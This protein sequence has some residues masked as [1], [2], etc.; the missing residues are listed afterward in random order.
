M[1]GEMDER[2]GYMTQAVRDCHLGDLS[3]CGCEVEM[4]WLFDARSC[5]MFLSSEMVRLFNARACQVRS[6]S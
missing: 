3:Q 4:L 2:G 1:R 5:Q 6:Q